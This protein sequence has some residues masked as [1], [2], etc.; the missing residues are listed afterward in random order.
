MTAFT[1]YKTGI[2][3]PWLHCGVQKDNDGKTLAV[4]QD[5]YGLG[6]Q[7]DVVYVRGRSNAG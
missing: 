1:Q 3:Q 2:S 5:M 7:K 6:T 4:Y